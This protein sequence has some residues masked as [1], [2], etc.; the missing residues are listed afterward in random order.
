MPLFVHVLSTNDSIVV[1]PLWV[2]TQVA[3]AD[4][5]FAPA[6]VHFEI[7]GYAPLAA[8]HGRLETRDDRHALHHHLRAGVVNV[9]I[10]DG[11]RDVDDP[12]QRRRGVHWRLPANPDRHWLI[13]CA[14]RAPPTTLAHELGHYFGNR[15]H[16]IVP[17]NIMSYL[18]GATP[19][20]DP[21]QLRRVRER[22]QEDRQRRRLWRRARLAEL[23]ATPEGIP[24][25]PWRSRH[26]P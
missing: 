16:S 6:G 5:V 17:G 2:Q 26:G 3:W 19:T 14:D 21:R 1:D 23:A 22:V 24:L 10:V 9:F 8:E 15:Q 13:L 25:L 4:Q 11:M 12:F 7:A 18:H 20:F